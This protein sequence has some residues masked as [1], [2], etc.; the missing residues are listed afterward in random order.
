MF[1]GCG[2]SGVECGC[3]MAPLTDC[4]PTCDPEPCGCGRGGL[5]SRGMF[6]GG[7]F[8]CKKNKGGCGCDT[9]CSPAPV[10]EPEP[11]PCCGCDDAPACGCRRK[12]GRGL[13]DRIG[14]I[15]CGTCGSKSTCGCN[16]DPA[17]SCGCDNAPH[18][19]CRRTRL[20]NSAA[21]RPFF[22]NSGCPTCDCGTPAAC[23]GGCADFAAPAN[24]GGSIYEPSQD[25]APQT[26]EPQAMEPAIEPVIVPESTEGSVDVPGADDGAYN[27][28]Q[29][30]V[31][32]SAFVI[33]NN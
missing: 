29:P 24:N 33:S 2:G 18:C 11:A 9:G 23:P 6:S 31:D 16:S 20:R 12:A 5:L 30:L 15:G 17:P 27:N 21:P 26:M 22:Q 25:M 8:S 3:E 7:L 28:R 4:G 19:G 14:N 10:I 13:L 1:S 32:P